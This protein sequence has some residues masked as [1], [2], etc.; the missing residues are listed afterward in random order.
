MFRWVLKPYY[1]L[2]FWVLKSRKSLIILC[3]E[4]RYT[5]LSCNFISKLG[6]IMYKTVINWESQFTDD[7]GSY[8]SLILYIITNWESFS[9]MMR[10][11]IYKQIIL[12]SIVSL[13]TSIHLFLQLISENFLTTLNNSFLLLIGSFLVKNQSLT[14]KYS[15]IR[16]N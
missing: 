12:T 9:K 5:N 2:V 4:V 10:S 11:Y 7:V 13:I 8:F 16:R 1:C 15:R 6:I 14:T 3:F